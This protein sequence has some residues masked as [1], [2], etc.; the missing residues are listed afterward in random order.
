MK[1]AARCN[2]GACRLVNQDCVFSSE[3]PVGAL[4]NLFIVA[5]GMGGH[6]AGEKASQEA[7]KCAV[8]YAA[9]AV[10]IP[11]EE[12][13]YEMVSKANKHVYHMAVA[14]PQMAGMGTTMVAASVMG[15]AIYCA[16]VGDSR[17]YALDQNDHF[18]RITMDHSLVEEMVRQGKI[19]PEE[20]R[21][22]PRRN[23]ITR[24]I[25]TSE[26]VETDLYKVPL[27]FAKM[28][29]LCSDGL[30][31][32]IED[33][34]ISEIIKVRSLTLSDRVDMLVNEANRNGG[35]DNISIILVDLERTE[36]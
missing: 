27:G 7:V 25:G 34:R 35:N 5:D 31:G 19:T 4:P 21:V 33:E 28:I 17:M 8:E 18:V 13:F 15:D 6:A 24:A 16:N 32:Q 1:V 3:E 23:Y 2:I 36:G 20:A 22:H 26:E 12:I 11:T 9:Q 30:N 29:L 10:N 14:N